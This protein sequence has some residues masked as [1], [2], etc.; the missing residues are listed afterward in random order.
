MSVKGLLATLLGLDASGIPYALAVD[1]NGY[2][3]AS[4]PGQA[5]GGTK[6]NPKGLLI[7][8]VGFS[9]TGVLKNLQVDAGGNL[10][11]TLVGGSANEILKSDGTDGEWDTLA[12]VIKETILF[13][14]GEIIIRDGSG[15]VVRLPAPATGNVLGE[16]GQI[17]AWITPTWGF[18]EGAKVYRTAVQSILTG[19]F[20]YIS[21][22][23]ELWDTDNCHDDTLFKTRLTCRTPGKYDVKGHV[24]WDIN[25]T[26]LRKAWI[27]L[28]GT[29]YMAGDTNYFFTDDAGYNHVADTIDLEMSDYLELAVFQS[30]G[31]ALNVVATA[32]YSPYFMMQRIG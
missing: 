9:P 32:Q 23:A 26:G 11:V 10:I 8:P 5:G 13:S 17:P 20:T 24:A 2:V 12:N 25:N 18:R 7:N 4:L 21:F 22:T 1:E 31:G 19:I 27:I 28:N 30:S 6:H 15:N 29:T 14:N 3:R 16:S